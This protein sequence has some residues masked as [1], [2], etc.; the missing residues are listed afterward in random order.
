M[1]P[2]V[3]STYGR[4][5]SLRC[6]PTRPN[7]ARRSLR[8]ARAGA[9]TALGVDWALQPRWLRD[10]SVRN[11]RGI[12]FRRTACSIEF[13]WRCGTASRGTA[14]YSAPPAQF[15]VPQVS[16]APP[17]GAKVPPRADPTSSY[18]LARVMTC[19]A[20][21]SEALLI[22]WAPEVCA[23]GQSRKESKFQ[24]LLAERAHFMGHH[25]KWTG[26]DRTLASWTCA[27]GSIAPYI[28]FEALPIGSPSTT[29]R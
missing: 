29:C 4:R 24:S 17:F 9:C 25:P 3:S 1:P 6:A 19:F 5:C 15:L 28:L 13:S 8:C 20:M 27:I 14:G 11:P 26:P 23:R 2:R 21:G 12:L 18:R 10:V 16:R 7:Q 22:C